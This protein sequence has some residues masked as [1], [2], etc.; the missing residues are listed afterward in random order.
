MGLGKGSKNVQK[1][2]TSL[3]P[4]SQRFVD[5]TRAGARGA[6]DVAR[7][8]PGQFFLGADPRSVQEIIQPFM[9][10]FQS[11]VIDATRGEF[12]ELRRRAVGGPG[13]TNQAA[14]AAGAFGG[15]RQGVAEGTRLGELDRAQTSQIAG[16]L[17]DNFRQAV[18]SGIPF[19]DRQRALAQQQAQEPLFREQQAQQFMNLGLGPTSGTTKSVD[20]QS[21]NLFKDLTGGALAVGGL[22]ANPTSVI[23]PSIGQRPTPQFARPPLRGGPLPGGRNPLGSISP[24]IFGG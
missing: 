19:A 17:S 12:D 15:S 10:P 5:E 20:K 16:L 24:T 14:T 4:A 1:T 2:T 7:N 11:N 3:D 6:A 8:A 22:L 13:G 9:D 23:A 21:G 18:A